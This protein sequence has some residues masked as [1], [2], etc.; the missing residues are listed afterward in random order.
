[1]NISDWLYQTALTRPG[2]VAIRDGRARHATYGQFARR[3]AGFGAE[4]MRRHGVRR[5]DRVAVFAR[6][7][8]QYLELLHGVLWIGAI[9]VP[10]NHKLH[11]REAAW[12]LKDAGA[13]VAVTETGAVFDGVEDV[14][15]VEVALGDAIPENAAEA[16]GLTPPQS[17]APDGVAWLFYTSGTTGRPKGVMLTHENLRA[18][19]LSYPLDVD[20]VLPGD[21][22]LYAAPMS[23]GAGLY[24]FH[25]IR[26]GLC[27]VVPPSRGFDPAEIAELAGALG[28]LV[29]FAAPTM[30]KRLIAHARESG[31]R[32]EGIRSIIYGGGPMYAADIREALEVFG[33]RFIQIYGQ[34]ES[35][36]TITALP[37]DLVADEVHPRAEVRRASVGF[38]QASVEVRVVDEDMR[39]RP[40]GEVGE[41]V[42]RGAPVMKGYWRNPEATKRTLLDGWLRTGDLGVLDADGFLTLTDRSKDVIISGGTNIY[43]REVEEVLLA[44]GQV[45]EV[46]VIGIPSA[47]WGEEVAAFVVP[48]GDVLVSEETLNA[49][50]KAHIASFKKPRH[51][52]FVKELPKN[53][54]GKIL[55]TTLR[56]RMAQGG[57]GC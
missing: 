33:P 54:Y 47:E 29:F 5:G 24:N 26:A 48:T 45:F 32:G 25:S 52:R 36:M 21:H 9:V 15:V 37:R 46:S 38:A 4:L 18:M 7:A 35:P 10:I 1:M 11:P 8:V 39:D 14:E 23:H 51:Y 30:V 31:Y 12:I 50:C 16:D 57:E 43:P 44:H 53:S 41:I 49:W 19:A 27:H 34:G 40:V 3:A 13:R 6:N 22:V 20:P 56:E 2:R 28:D 55:K 17:L 42:V